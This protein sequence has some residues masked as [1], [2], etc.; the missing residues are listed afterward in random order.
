MK[1]R[2]IEMNLRVWIFLF[3]V[4]ICVI[5]RLGAQGQSPE[6]EKQ[7]SS[8]V[9]L[10][11]LLDRAGYSPGEIDGM[12]GT[13]IEKAV[14]LFQENNRLPMS[15]LADDETMSAL[16]D[17]ELNDPLIPY[18]VTREDAAGPF[19]KHIPEDPMQQ[20]RLPHLGYTSIVE[21]LSEKFHCSPDL[22]K[23][24][25]P[26]S[27]FQ[28]GQTIQVPNLQPSNTGPTEK[29]A[30]IDRVSGKAAASP[31]A[32]TIIVTQKSSDVVLRGPDN[33]I[34][35][36]APA[37]VGSER[38]PLPSG[39]WKVTV[40][41]KNPVFYYLPELFWDAEPEHRKTKIA[42]GPNNPVGLVWIG[43]S[44]PHYGLHGT[45]EPGSIGHSQSHGCVRMTNWDALHLAALVR[46]GTRVVFQ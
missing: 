38:D 43:V 42:S 7:P 35:F 6:S 16:G 11:I 24:I 36:Y 3:L 45:P 34:M 21:V 44:A 46:A 9:R 33:E 4:C 23:R 26:R 17:Q 32:S 22:L 39:I 14:I 25:N 37:T 29:R 12:M 27:K 19:S 41:R 30:P 18:T 31:E 20:A 2:K 8:V 1:A 5:C 13:N 15:G 10:Q 28:E 40:I